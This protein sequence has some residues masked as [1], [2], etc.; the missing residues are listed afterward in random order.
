MTFAN[1]CY[2]P[3]KSK[4]GF[5]NGSGYTTQYVK[6][7][8][9]GF[10]DTHSKVIGYMFWLIG[11]TGAHRFYYGRPVSGLVW[12][13]TF[14]L[15]GIGWLVDLFLIPSM[16]READQRFAPGTLDYSISWILLLFFGVFGVHR[17]Y[18]GKIITGL[19]YFLTGGLFMIGYIYDVATLNEQVSEANLGQQNRQFG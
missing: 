11:F 5:D 1:P 12:F 15:L 2:P 10:A 16:D 13:L 18:Q 6:Y 4:N 14:G 17:I 8:P 9:V 19:V 3:V 7:V